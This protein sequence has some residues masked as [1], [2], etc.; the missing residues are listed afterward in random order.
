MHVCFCSSSSFHFRDMI[1]ICQHRLAIAGYVLRVCGYFLSNKVMVVNKHVCARHMHACCA[2]AH[3]LGT[4]TCTCE[5]GC[6]GLFH[7][8]FSLVHFR[9]HR[10][11]LSCSKSHM[12]MFVSLYK[13]KTAWTIDVTPIHTRRYIQYSSSTVHLWASMKVLSIL[14][15]FI[16]ALT[17]EGGAPVISETFNATVSS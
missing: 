5:F 1:T 2:H 4:C 16:Y 9:A 8:L 6:I 7:G 10:H 12:N 13:Y 3:A 17:A 11:Q 15:V 14:L